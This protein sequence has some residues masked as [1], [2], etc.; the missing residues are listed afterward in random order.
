[1][2]TLLVVL[3]AL[4]AAEGQV[5]TPAPGT[6][7]MPL[8]EYNKLLELANRPAKKPDGPPVP[9]AIKRA[10]LD[11]QAGP[12]SV[13]GAVQL[14]GEVFA[15]GV[16]RVPLLS[17]MI[18][19]DAQ[20]KERELPLEQNA[21]VHTA[22][23]PGPG[24]FSITLQAGMPLTFEPGRAS[25]RFP[26]PAAGAVDLVFSVPS[27]GAYVNVSPGL[28]TSRAA[29]D[30]R[31]VVSATLVPGQTVQIWWATRE[32][33]APVVHELR[34][35][36]DVKTLVS[37]TESGI[38][39]AALVDV[40]VVQGEP[41]QFELE[42]PEGYEITSATGATLASSDSGPGVLTLRVRPQ[43]SQQFLIS[44]ERAVN[45]ATA[46]VPLMFVRGAQRET[47]EVLVD[48]A[49]ALELTAAERGGL[50]RMD[51]RETSPYL[52]AM[53]H[54][55]VHAAFR[56]HRQAA[57]KAGLALQWTRYPGAN[58]LAAVAEHAVVTTLVTSE[59]KSLT[60]VRLMVH[61]QAQPF[62]KVELPAGA[63]IL[64]ADVAGEK[65]KPAQGTDG[66][67]VPLLRPGFRPQ[68]SYPVTFVFQHSGAPFARKGSAELGLP[69][70]DI[71]VSLLR[72]EV[73]LP[74]RY[75][76]KSLG[77]DV[78]RDSDYAPVAEGG[79]A[80]AVT[81]SGPGGWIGGRV[82]DPTGAVVPKAHVVVTHLG[83]GQN[84][85]TDSDANG[86]WSIF[87]V[88]S[89]RLRVLVDA[90]G[91]QRET[92]DV[93]QPVEGATT[94]N[95]TLRVGSTAETVTV[96][97][98]AYPLQTSAASMINTETSREPKPRK[99]QVDT[100]ASENVS[101]L[102]RRVAGVLPI[103]IDVPRSGASYRFVRPLVIDEET[104]VT[105]S[106]KAR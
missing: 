16:V 67:R 91:F 97:A 23:L 58:T 1:M 103:A 92:R 82:L 76:V 93:L 19:S 34:F 47:G 29:K 37:V 5:S 52:R 90:Q 24:E 83:S 59:G 21:G 89:G 81:G 94:Q 20:Q 12:E 79:A 7:T 69:K 96:E 10:H 45:G 44:M 30:G 11:L 13:A 32:A 6:V 95:F 55:S 66:A 39:L 51:V 85:E 105:F 15:R 104:K 54:G 71:P 98:Q 38:A 68:S 49:G 73:F 84:F 101:N 27:D 18:V 22:L 62:L 102:Q 42:V 28:I 8:D 99:P 31:T 106:Y 33:A 46:E 65:V 63:I 60:E 2:K 100:T 72:W 41:S 64:T 3:C 80:Y 56:Y 17:G 25:F 50:K 26:A 75:K 87:N 43:K 88:A 86:R 48:T 40:S 36:S 35:L 53:S 4:A 78:I 74:E 61:N 9:F 77:G 70:M 57:E 14:D